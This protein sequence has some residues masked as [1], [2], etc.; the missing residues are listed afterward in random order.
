MD[1][2]ELNAVLVLILLPAD[3]HRVAG[4]DEG[5]APGDHRDA[6]SD[7]GG[8]EGAGDGGDI[9]DQTAAPGVMC[10]DLQAEK[11]DI[12]LLRVVVEGFHDVFPVVDHV[13]D[14]GGQGQKRALEQQGQEDDAEDNLKDGLPPVAGGHHRHD[15]KYDGGGSPQPRPGHQELLP[16]GGPEGGEEEGHR[17]RPGH[18]GEKEG[19]QDGG[20]K[21]LGKPGGKH[22]ESQ[23]EEDEH[24]HHPVEGVKKVHQGFLAG[25]LLIA[26]EDAGDVG[27]QV[28]VSAGQGRQG[29]GGQ[30]GG[31]QK[32]GLKAVGTQVHAAENPASSQGH[33]D[34]A[35]DAEGQLRQ[36]GPQDAAGGNSPAHGRQHG[37]GHH[38]GAGIVA[39]A[40]DLQHGGSAVFEVQLSGAQDGEYGGGV[41]G[42]QHGADEQALQQA[43][44]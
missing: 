40:L 39:A 5:V 18:Q 32:Y 12:G 28:S 8:D 17:R 14:P 24:L 19:D 41:R 23:Q 11:A 34:S 37:D 26:Q 25:N 31:H 2:A 3:D 4:L 27:A 42:A 20:E 44:L 13:Q 22:Q 1:F 7:D 16:G 36:D 35:G 15:G 33:E 43:G 30:G 29:V 6:V 9:P 21:H 38:V 10:P